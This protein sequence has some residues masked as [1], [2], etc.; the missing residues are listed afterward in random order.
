MKTALILIVLL[1]VI[2]Y[3]TIVAAMALTQRR[4]LY[5]PD[6]RRP[7]P[8]AAGVPGARALTI[9]TADGLDLLA[10]MASPAGATRPVVLYLHGNAGNIGYRA[11]RMARLNSFGWGVLLPEYRGYGGNPGR[12]SEAGL[13]EDAR[14]A[15]AALRGMGVPGW[16]IL[17]WAES[18][19]TALAVRLATEMDVGGVLLEAPFTSVAAVARAYFPLV[20]TGLLLRDRFDLIGRIGKV[21]APVMVMTGGRDEI[22]PTAM[23]RAVFAAANEPKQLWWV[24]DAGHDDM[25]EA[26]ALEAARAFVRQY[27]Q[28]GA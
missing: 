25:A 20:P 27:W 12:P 6:T 26:G 4:L 5:F 24:P 16:R 2:P 18:L 3:A 11:L 1:A 28:A 21:H 19:G 9:R 14:A 8:S 23:G 13:A 22:V 10:W 17:L 15:H 7:E